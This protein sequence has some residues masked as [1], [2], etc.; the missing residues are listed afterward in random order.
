MIVGAG[1]VIKV[2]QV[3]QVID[4]GAAFAVAPGCC[5][6][7]AEEALAKNFPFAPGIATPS[8]IE[9]ALSLGLTIM[10]VFPAM[11]LGGIP[12][13]KSIYVPFAHLGIR[14]IPLGGLGVNDVAPYLKEEMI[15]SI[16]GSW[17]TVKNDIEN[18]RWDL[19]SQKAREA[20]D[21]VSCAG[22]RI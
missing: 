15:V 3:Q 20:V 9:A 7:V 16:G 19:I 18:R 12:Y 10:K 2:E 22:G 5:L 17:I 11:H 14:F 4:A 13:M 6:R 1:T 8:D 21:L